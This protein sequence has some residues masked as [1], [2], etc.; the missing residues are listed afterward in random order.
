[1]TVPVVYGFGLVVKGCKAILR[2]GSI[3]YALHRTDYTS[4]QQALIDGLMA[5]A[6]AVISALEPPLLP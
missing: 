6:Q 2:F 5:A 1:M 4:E 3:Y